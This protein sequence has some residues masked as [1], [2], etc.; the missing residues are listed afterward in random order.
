MTKTITLKTAGYNNPDVSNG[1]RNQMN[2]YFNEAKQNS[3]WNNKNCSN[4]TNYNLSASTKGQNFLETATGIAA[5]FT[6]LAAI[7]SPVVTL[8]TLNKKSNGS[9]PGNNNNNNVNINTQSGVDG[10]NSAITNYDQNGDVKGLETQI[11]AQEQ[12]YEANVKLIANM[13]KQEEAENTKAQKTL[14]EAKTVNDKQQKAYNTADE[15]VTKADEAVGVAKAGVTSAQ[16]AYDAAKL[17]Y[18]NAVATNPKADNTALKT[19]MENANTALGEATKKEKDAELKRDKAKQTRASE[20]TNLD[21]TLKNLE[22]AKT[23]AGIT[24]KALADIPKAKQEAEVKNAQ[25]KTVIDQ[26]K[27]KIPSYKGG[28]I[29]KE[30]TK[31]ENKKENLDEGCSTQGTIPLPQ[32]TATDSKPLLVSQ[33]PYKYTWN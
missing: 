16:S 19:A 10:L 4:N 24:A 14:E 1:M 21:A 32:Q 22:T 5:I 12:Q 26:A 8:A 15:A 17:A 30:E 9:N 3:I 6:G 18:N 27:A 31:K 7:A 23:A 11:K 20:K 2:K 33:A 25:L 28:E 13:G 29:K